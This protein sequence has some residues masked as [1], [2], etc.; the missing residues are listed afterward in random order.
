MS[1]LIPIID[2]SNLGMRMPPGSSPL[3][4]SRPGPA[5]EITKTPQAGRASFPRCRPGALRL[6]PRPI[7][8][9]TKDAL[10]GQLAA[11]VALVANAVSTPPRHSQRPRRPDRQYP[12]APG[13][14]GAPTAPS[15]PHRTRVSQRALRVSTP[16]DP[17]PACRGAARAVSTPTVWPHC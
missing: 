14:V 6:G 10:R 13:L 4:K 8:M 16:V 3:L 17:P 2:W 5:R 12:A 15:V 9:E 7:Q 1:S 11:A